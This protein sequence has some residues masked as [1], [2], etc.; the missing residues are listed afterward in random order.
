MAK[1]Q[2]TFENIVGTEFTCN[3]EKFIVES[4]REKILWFINLPK[5]IPYSWGT[6]ERFNGYVGNQFII[7]KEGPS[8]ELYQI[9]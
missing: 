8:Q 6:I 2:F 9:Y 5:N 3:G 4:V 1:K 7:T